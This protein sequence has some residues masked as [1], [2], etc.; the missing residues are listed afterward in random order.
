MP[1]IQGHL[2]LTFKGSSAI[3]IQYIFC[4]IP[5]IAPHSPLAVCSVCVLKNTPV[6]VYSPVSVNGKQR[7]DR[8][9]Q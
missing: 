4:Q 3:L 6:F 8:T 1:L 9:K 5:Q 2:T 7:V